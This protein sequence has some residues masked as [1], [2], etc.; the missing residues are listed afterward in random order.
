[1]RGDRNEMIFLL[2]G[3]RRSGRNRTNPPRKIVDSCK[4]PVD[5]AGSALKRGNP[6]RGTRCDEEADEIYCSNPDLENGTPPGAC[7]LRR[8]HAPGEK[9]QEQCLI[10][11]TRQQGPD[12][13]E[14]GR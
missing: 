8:D 2:T 3:S 12:G 6:A 11:D 5:L 10:S 14:T 13:E 7:L 1:M 9:G 4:L